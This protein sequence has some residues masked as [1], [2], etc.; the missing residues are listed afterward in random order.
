M[1]QFGCSK[2]HSMRPFDIRM[3]SDA[4]FGAYLSGGIDSSAVV[5]TMVRHSTE[6]VRTFS[7][8]FREA[9][10]S[11]LDHARVVAGQFGTIHNEL[12]VEP[13]A[14]MDHWSTAVLRRGA[15]VSEA[16]DV[17]IFMLSEMASR[18][19]K[20]VLTGEG[21]DELMGGYPKHRAEAVDWSVSMADAQWIARAADLS[22]GAFIASWHAACEDPC[23]GRGRTRS[24]EPHACMVRR[25]FGWRKR[26]NAGSGAIGN[27]AGS[28]PIFV[29]DTIQFAAHLI[30]RSDILASR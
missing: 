3:R 29:G 25:P 12:V 13:D 6:P 15:P 28:L 16:S 11:E 30:L 7:V 24:R 19:V 27:T 5:A 20:M 10:Y 2:R 26:S 9:E 17:P 14:F 4:P 18:S 23:I 22:A 21:A 8:G 1:M